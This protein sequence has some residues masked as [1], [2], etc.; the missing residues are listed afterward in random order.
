MGPGSGVTRYP[1]GCTID[2]T[3][4]LTDPIRQ[5]AV[6]GSFY[7]DDIAVLGR[8]VIIRFPLKIATYDLWT[9]AIYNVAD[10][11]TLTSYT[12]WSP[13]TFSSGWEVAV[14][15]PGDISGYSNPYQMKIAA[16]EVEWVADP[17]PL[18][19]NQQVL[20]NFTGT[21]V[22]PASGTVFRIQLD[23]E[24]ANYTWPT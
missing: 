5:E 20:I 12:A 14:A 21:V 16:T 6:I 17:I 7:P 11:S 23:N 8:A 18:V 19:G 2:F 13:V 9:Q 22:K 24:T 1:L 4:G 15:S 3:N 10:A